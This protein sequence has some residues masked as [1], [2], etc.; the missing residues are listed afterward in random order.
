MSSW[1]KFKLSLK[2]SFI[3]LLPGMLLVKLVPAISSF[4]SVFKLGRVTG[5]VVVVEAS[6]VGYTGPGLAP[7]RDFES[8]FE[9]DIF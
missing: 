4:T 9:E 1:D 5:R 2:V 3:C 6:T 7:V 8:N